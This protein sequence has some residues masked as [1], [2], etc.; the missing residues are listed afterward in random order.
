MTKFLKKG[1][2]VVYATCSLDLK[3][4]KWLLMNFLVTIKNFSIIPPNTFL[5]QDWVNSDR[6]LM[7]MPHET[8]SDGLFELVLQKKM[9]LY[10]NI[11]YYL[12]NLGVL[13][14]LSIF[15]MIYL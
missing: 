12:L 1:G 14:A 13:M 8:G 9:K 7:T 10:N 15:I 4:I 6:F 5:P 3:R 2:K 11:K